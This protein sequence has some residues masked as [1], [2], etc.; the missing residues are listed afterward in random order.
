[1][2]KYK[3][4]ELIE[5]A[6]NI[7]DISNTDFLTHK[8]NIEYINDAW[9]SVYQW[10]INKGDKQFVEEVE[11]SGGG[12]NGYVEYELPDNFYQML[13]LKSSNGFIVPRK[14]ESESLNSATYEIVNNRLRLYGCTSNLILTYYVNPIWITY[15]DRPIEVESLSY[16][17]EVYTSFNNSVLVYNE[18]DE[19]FIL[20]NVITGE[21]IA[22]LT[23]MYDL[24]G[25]PFVA[26][27]HVG[28]HN[29]TTLTVYD[30]SGNEINTASNIDSAFVLGGMV[31]YLKGGHIY[32]FDSL[33][34]ATNENAVNIV[35]GKGIEDYFYKDSEGHLIHYLYGEETEYDIENVAKVIYHDD[36]YT[37]E[38]SEAAGVYVTED[39]KTLTKIQV[40]GAIKAVLSYGV[41]YYNGFYNI[42]ST[43]EDTEFNF[44][45]ELYVSLL[46]CDLASRY[47]MK[48]NADSS[49]VDNLYEH[50]RTTFMNT[51]TQDGNY[52]RITNVYR[53]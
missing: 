33:D 46:A 45:N 10:L 44:P 16:P 30:Y 50:M 53:S 48:M 49:G 18:T 13:S 40:P 3:A 7:A 8:E 42:I 15:P 38:T 20:K 17:D 2:K 11:L 52:T 27:G 43:Y 26:N 21:T 31:C 14:A 51:L 6:L 36:Y 32:D 39:F 41:L 1:M 5:K 34:L 23:F 19:T 12:S 28:V 37:V 29:G 47:L 24:G 35:G 22:D 4:S 25:N 9:K